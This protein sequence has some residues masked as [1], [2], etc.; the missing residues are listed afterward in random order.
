VNW[1]KISQKDWNRSS[2]IE[3]L[4]K[5]FELMPHDDA[6]TFH[7]WTEP[8]L[9]HVSFMNDNQDIRVELAANIYWSGI[10]DIS[11]SVSSRSGEF[12][13]TTKTFSAKDFKQMPHDIVE[14]VYK[15][16]DDP[17]YGHEK[18]DD[19]FPGDDDNRPRYPNTPDPAMDIK[20]DEYA[21]ARV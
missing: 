10:T 20:E 7:R 3:M 2:W 5:A 11:I 1:Y 19:D 4:E 15:M 6:G 17:F 8:N 14:E 16:I 9:G 13:S 21:V 12:G 18:N